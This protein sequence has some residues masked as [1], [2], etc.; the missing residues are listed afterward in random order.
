M[1]GKYA[2]KHGKSLQKRLERIFSILLSIQSVALLASK[3]LVLQLRRKCV[4]VIIANEQIIA[5]YV[6]QL[7][8]FVT[9]LN[10]RIGYNKASLIVKNAHTYDTTLKKASI[11]LNLVTEQK[12]DRIV[13]P[14]KMTGP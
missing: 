4:A 8:M 9:T 14:N 1:Q 10:P 2:F 11:S 13:A 6:K 5:G 3:R 7:L 12:F